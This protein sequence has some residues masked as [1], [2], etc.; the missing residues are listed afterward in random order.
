MALLCGVCFTLAAAADTSNAIL[1]VP[2]LDYLLAG[3][4]HQRLAHATSNDIQPAWYALSLR[5][6]HFIP[7]VFFVLVSSVDSTEFAL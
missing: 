6:F 1:L 4:K 7:S 5:L 3:W 2:R